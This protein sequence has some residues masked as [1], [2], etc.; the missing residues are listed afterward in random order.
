MDDSDAL[1]AESAAC[2]LPSAVCRLPVRAR[3]GG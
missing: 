1:P 3:G 2:R